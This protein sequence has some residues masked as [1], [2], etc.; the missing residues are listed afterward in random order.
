MISDRSHTLYYTI[1][2][3]GFESR[4]RKKNSPTKNENPSN[5]LYVC[6]RKRGTNVGEKTQKTV[7]A[8]Y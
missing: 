3:G 5:I 4:E 1:G 7:P 8:N 6:P 2:N